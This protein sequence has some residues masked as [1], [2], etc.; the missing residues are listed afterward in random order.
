MK[1]GIRVMAAYFEYDDGEHKSFINE[2]LVNV[3]NYSL[4][5]NATQR[6]KDLKALF[7][8]LFRRVEDRKTQTPAAI[9]L[10]TGRN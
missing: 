6:D 9:G 3:C 5:I 10:S 2:R 8:S 4:N 1:Q 7:K